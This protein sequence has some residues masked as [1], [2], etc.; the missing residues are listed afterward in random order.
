MAQRGLPDERRAARNDASGA[1]VRWSPR[2]VLVI[3]NQGVPP[4]ICPQCRSA[5]CYRSHRVGWMDFLLTAGGCRP[6]RCQ[7]CERRFYAWRVA[8][9]HARFVH[10]PRCGNFDLDRS[11]RD[12]VDS[13]PLLWARRLLRVPAYR[14]D[15]C[16]KRFFS[17][18][19]VR[20]ILP[21][22]AGAAERKMTV[23]MRTES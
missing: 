4:M 14:C 1:K 19:S 6:W 13:G 23:P 16:R 21:S 18:R 9:A 8:V 2:G 22:M 20:R 11:L 3:L 17:V 5:D 15:S 12:R 7:T 10:C